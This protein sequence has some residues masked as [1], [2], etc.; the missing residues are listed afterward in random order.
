MTC[1]QERD[2]ECVEQKREQKVLPMHRQQFPRLGERQQRSGPVSWE[3][4]GIAC[5][6]RQRAEYCLWSTDQ[7]S[8]HFE[9]KQGVLLWFGCFSYQSVLHL[10]L[11]ITAKKRKKLL[12]F[13]TGSLGESQ[14]P[15]A[16]FYL[17]SWSIN[18]CKDLYSLL[19]VNFK[20]CLSL[21]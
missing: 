14:K 10:Y 8:G 2:T 19:F 18:I 17:A 6:A 13:E 4:L 11:Q 16:I 1:G 15:V 3:K 9:K 12:L 7:S 21:N 5:S 20:L